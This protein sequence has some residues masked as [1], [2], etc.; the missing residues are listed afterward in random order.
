MEKNMSLNKQISG[1]FHPPSKFVLALDVDAS[2][3]ILLV[4]FKDKISIAACATYPLPVA[5]TN[6]AL[7]A[8]L[9]DFTKQHA[10]SVREVTV[11]VPLK[12]F[13]IKRLQFPAVPDNELAQVVQWRLKEELSCD[14]T[15][16]VFAYQ[17]IKKTNKPDGTVTEDIM[18]A[19]ADEAQV[20]GIA[21]SFKKQGFHCQ[22]VSATPFGYASLF[23]HFPP[24]KDAGLTCVLH[25]KL[26]MS[27]FAVYQQGMLV[28]YR[29]V[30][31]AIAQFQDAVTGTFATSLGRVEFT[32]QEI[33][34]IIFSYG[35]PHTEFVYKEKVS[36]GQLTG[37]LHPV[38]ERL[39][40]EI[41]RSL[42]YY[43]SQFGDSA[44]TTI[45]F[46]GEG[47][48]IPHLREALE[49]E[50]SIAVSCVSLPS[51]V[52]LPHDLEPS[53]VP[54]IAAVLGIA[55]GYKTGVNLLPGEYRQ[56]TIEKFEWK[57]LRWI[58]FIAVMVLGLLFAVL[59]VDVA[60]HRKKLESLQ[61]NMGILAQVK[62]TNMHV[63]AL[64]AF[65]QGVKD[66]DRETGMLLKKLSSL[67]PE[68][69][70]LEDLDF[71]IQGKQGMLTGY[72][73]KANNNPEALLSSFVTGL[74]K[75]GIIQD[76]T[77]VSVEKNV[78]N[79]AEV[80][81]FRISFQIP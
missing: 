57:S 61:V 19:M 72:I 62:A 2:V 12:P 7:A 10:L 20:S 66:H 43:A 49:K 47:V 46:A 70:F 41:K 53:I 32:R 18:C 45:L 60:G 30:P 58:A 80:D 25:M 56:G 71:D 3:H 51:A 1:I 48:R 64:T 40:Q 27:I 22:A 28:F 63:A 38:V 9:V 15:K 68:D 6:D 59:Q 14:I 29:E 31:V 73:R 34:E 74:N 37:M 44:M 36:S 4:S 69:I 42:E 24:S 21:E 39:S 78:H 77:I 35:I 23:E 67:V 55:L 8:L 54:T 5:I 33:E 76:A 65:C 13:C 50:L 79:E 81:S 75:L 17:I 16:S 26:A 52:A 11:A